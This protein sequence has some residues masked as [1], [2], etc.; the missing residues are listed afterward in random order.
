[1]NRLIFFTENYQL[2]SKKDV[3]FGLQNFKNLTHLYGS[4]I[5]N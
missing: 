2:F 1:M 4:T 5:R 3:K